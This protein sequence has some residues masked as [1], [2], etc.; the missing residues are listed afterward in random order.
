MSFL[1]LC[2]A[3][4]LSGCTLVNREQPNDPPVLDS[5]RIDRLVVRRGQVVRVQVVATDEDY[6]PLFFAWESYRMSPFVLD[7]VLALGPTGHLDQADQLRSLY[8]FLELGERMEGFTDSLAQMAN[9]WYAPR[10]IQGESERF[11]LLVAVR[12]RDCR[13]IADAVEHDDCTTGVSQFV[14]IYAVEV[15]QRAPEL[16]APID[17]VIVP[18]HQPAFDL[19]VHVTDLDGDPLQVVWSQTEGPEIQFST[20]TPQGESRLQAVPFFLGD[21]A[22]AVQ[23]SDGADTV[24]AEVWVRVVADLIPPAGGMVSLTLP[25][26]KAYEIDRY[27]YPNQFGSHP[28]LPDDWFAAARLCASQQKRLCSR[29]EWTH[30]CGGS[31]SGSHSSADDAQFADREEF[32]HRFCNTAGSETAPRSLSPSADRAASGTYPNCFSDYGVYDLTGNVRE[33]VGHINASAR[34]VGGVSESD[35]RDAPPDSC[36]TFTEFEPLPA[37]FDY[38]DPDQLAEL[39]GEYSDGYLQ[40]NVGF[41]CCR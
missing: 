16:R 17:T 21:Y 6:D 19:T 41:R 13:S 36:S 12:D 28:K 15:T 14:Q 29:A 38:L 7:A 39:G 35:A 9:S 3:A 8:G 32:G 2:A 33:W 37:G 18:F 23:A 10:V 11:L 30:A 40:Y 31:T 24:S 34:M 26:G 27:E 25:D 4:L 20:E 1:L 22:F 5:S